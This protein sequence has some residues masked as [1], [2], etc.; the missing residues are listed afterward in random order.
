MKIRSLIYVLVLVSAPQDAVPDRSQGLG[1]KPL[2]LQIP[3]RL[4]ERMHVCISPITQCN[5]QHAEVCEHKV[6]AWENLRPDR[7][8]ASEPPHQ[9][10]A[11]L[12][13]PEP[14]PYKMHL[15]TLLLNALSVLS[16]RSPPSVG[17][18]D[19]QYGAPTIS[20][21]GNGQYNGAPGPPAY[22]GPTPPA[23][24]PG[25]PGGGPPG[26]YPGAPPS[27]PPHPTP[28]AGPPGGGPPGP[29][30][31][32]GGPAGGWPPVVVGGSATVVLSPDKTVIVTNPLVTVDPHGDPRAWTEPPPG[33]YYTSTWECSGGSCAWYMKLRQWSAAPSVR[34]GR[35]AVG[36]GC[37]WVGVVGVAGLAVAVAQGQWWS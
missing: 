5:V 35:R 18:R 20:T 34:L 17:V 7:H 30:G 13:R 37:G 3:R 12:V 33:W 4:P 1:S 36:F 10:R 21:W 23:V 25:P 29:G 28:P 32:Y 8:R 16:S 2:P 11:S 9:T 6:P 31:D 19:P 24:P 14:T 26:A 27:Y 22:P 15:P